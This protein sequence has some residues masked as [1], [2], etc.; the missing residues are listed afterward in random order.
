FLTIIMTV[1]A[2]GLT[3]RSLAQALGVTSSSATG[4]VIVGC[5]AIGLTIG[6]LFKE[7]GESVVI[8]D[9]DQAASE[10]AEAQGF[11]VYVG[12]ALNGEILEEADISSIGTFLAITNNGEV[13]SVIAERAQEEF[14]PPRVVAVLPRIESTETDNTSRGEVR[15]PRFSVKQWNTFIEDDAV[16]TDTYSFTEDGLD[17][18][19]QQVNK[20]IRAGDMIPLITEQDGK[21]EVA[22]G[23]TDWQAGSQLTFLLHDPTP[24]LIKRL[25]GSRKPS[26]KIV[27]PTQDASSR[28]NASPGEAQ[29]EKSATTK[30]PAADSLIADTN[31][32]ADSNTATN[33]DSNTASGSGDSKPL[34]PE[35]SGSESDPESRA[36]YRN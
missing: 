6:G 36:S 26:R 9:T 19:R 24:Q 32:R 18:Q 13:N 14:Q 29:R 7:R 21:L 12:S 31:G 23:E 28:T 17:L 35:T 5:N 1:F 20:L 11:E 8:I 27:K 3:A 2:Q 34:G 15:T 10:K 25:S 4:V 22:L 33:S 30:S 16:Q